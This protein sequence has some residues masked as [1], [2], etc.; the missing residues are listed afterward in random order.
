MSF[1]SESVPFS[2]N[3]WL[4]SNFLSVFSCCS[5]SLSLMFYSPKGT[6]R[7]MKGRKRRH[8]LLNPLKVT[9]AVGGGSYSNL[10]GGCHDNDHFLCLYPNYEK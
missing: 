5:V 1:L 8:W 10:G 2:E 3:V 6:E 7:T 4:L 9:S